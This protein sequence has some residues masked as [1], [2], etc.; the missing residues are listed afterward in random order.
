VIEEAFD[1]VLRTAPTEEKLRA[2]KERDP[3][4]AAEQGLI[5]REEAARVKEARAAV[6]KAVEVDAFPG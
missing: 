3:D 2:A 6:A 4:A 1:L 5:S